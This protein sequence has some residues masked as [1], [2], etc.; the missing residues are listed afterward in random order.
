MKP[1]RYASLLLER[2]VRRAES[3]AI[4]ER[5]EHG[6]KPESPAAIA[7]VAAVAGAGLVALAGLLRRR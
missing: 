7:I 1:S 6:E 5:L 3:P 2:A 4:L